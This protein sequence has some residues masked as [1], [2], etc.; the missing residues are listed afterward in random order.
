MVLQQ[1]T[2]HTHCACISVHLMWLLWVCAITT[3]YLSLM[4]CLTM[5]KAVSCCSPHVNTVSLINKS[6][7][8]LCQCPIVFDE[9]TMQASHT[10]HTVHLCFVL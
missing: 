6:F 1:H 7:E 2:T 5:L 4:A 9:V 8:A 3:T 10:Q